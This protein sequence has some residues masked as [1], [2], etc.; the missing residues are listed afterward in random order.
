VAAELDLFSR[1]GVGWSMKADK[2]ARQV[3]D[4]LM[5]AVWCRGQADAL[6]HHSGQGSKYT[7]KQ[8][9]RLLADN[10]II[11]SMSQAGTVWA[12]SAKEG[13]FSSLKTERVDRRAIVTALLMLSVLQY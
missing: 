5:M 4:A 10:G 7:N 3:M 11:Y 13:F 2:D 8:F 9:Q 1:R 6:L 12:N